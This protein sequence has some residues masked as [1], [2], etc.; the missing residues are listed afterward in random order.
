MTVIEVF[1]EI[2]PKPAPER[3]N[4]VRRIFM[5][6][7]KIPWHP[8]FV[9]ALQLEFEDYADVL[10]FRAEQPLTTEPLRIDVVVVKKKPGAAIGKNI[11]RI[12]RTHNI[13]EFKGPRDNFSAGDAY[14]TFAYVFLYAVVWNVDVRDCALTLIGAKKST[15][16]TDCLETAL[17]CRVE[18]HA[19]GVYYVEGA[20]FPIQIVQTRRLSARENLWLASLRD[21]LTARGAERVLAESGKRRDAGIA[22]YMYALMTARSQ[23]FM[24]AWDMKKQKVTFEQLMT[25]I[26]ADLGLPEK[27][28]YQKA[29]ETARSMKAEGTN[30]DFICRHTGLT[31]EQVRAL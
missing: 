12:F 6:K 11:G 29:L 8:A 22:A 19:E 28:Q 16:L 9:Q 17:G 30:I 3:H 24:E 4:R 25:K 13:F 2:W 23:T 20:A 7:E 18:K 5:A 1:L 31:V 15:V 21:D 10:E 26:N 14:K 27:W